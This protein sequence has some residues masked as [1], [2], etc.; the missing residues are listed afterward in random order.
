MLVVRALFS[1]STTYPYS[2]LGFTFSDLLAA[3]AYPVA[4]WNDTNDRVTSDS[5]WPGTLSSNATGNPT[6]SHIEMMFSDDAGQVLAVCSVGDS[7]EVGTVDS[8][9]QALASVQAACEALSTSSVYLSH[10]ARGWGGKKA[11]EYYNYLLRQLEDQPPHILHWLAWSQNNTTSE[12]SAERAMIADVVQRCQQLGVVPIIGTGI[13]SNTSN[14][15]LDDARN[16]LNTYA[17]T[18]GIIVCDR[19]AVISDGATPAR[20][21]SKYGGGYHPNLTGYAD[22][23][24]QAYIPAVRSA[25]AALGFAV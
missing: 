23:L 25:V 9:T 14:Q 22:M 2:A 12:V 7:T 1:A 4:A 18:L 24:A 11:A 21:K 8:G 10:I 5:A 15:A 3:T 16:A 19:D 17:K 13:P 20:Y 6:F